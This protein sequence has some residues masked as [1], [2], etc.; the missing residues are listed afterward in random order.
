[1]DVA[2][3]RAQIPAFASAT[4]WP[5]ADV[6]AA[7]GISATYIATE[8]WGSFYDEGVSAWVADRLVT[9]KVLSTIG[10]LGALTGS[11]TLKTVGTVTVGRD[12]QIILAQMHNPYL[13][14]TFGQRFAYLQNLAFGGATV[15][16]SP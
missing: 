3:F 8:E 11:E 6:T 7:L 12:A 13:R 4:D 2:G 16:T 1:M 9:D 15:S 10:P 5:D 14:T